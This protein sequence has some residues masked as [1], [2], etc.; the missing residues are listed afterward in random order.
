MKVIEVKK[1]YRN[2]EFIHNMVLDEV[3]KDEHIDE[4]VADWAESDPAGQMYGYNVEWKEITDPGKKIIIMS[5]EYVRLSEQID[6]MRKRK[7][8][9]ALKIEQT[10]L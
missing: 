4:I 10:K 1:S 2:G 5:G 6:Q 9:I 8:K 7:L 3:Y